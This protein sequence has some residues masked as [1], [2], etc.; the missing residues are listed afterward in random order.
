MSKLD[1]ALAEVLAC[2]GCGG[3]LHTEAEPADDAVRRVRC[4]KCGASYP[5]TDDVLDFLSPL[6]HKSTP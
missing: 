3:V 5:I 6:D 1:E 2:P 4:T